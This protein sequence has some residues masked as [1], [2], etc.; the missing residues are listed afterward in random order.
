ML[1]VLHAGVCDGQFLLWGETPAEAEVLASRPLGRN[2]RLRAGAGRG[3]TPP[4]LPYD[5]GAKTLAA[6]LTAAG[7]ERMADM[8]PTEE[9]V[10]WLPTVEHT[11]VASSP[12]IDP[13]PL[14]GHG[15]APLRRADGRGAV[16]QRGAD[17]AGARG[18]HR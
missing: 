13:G 8:R 12:L 1:V 6:V 16:Q 2:R 7:F 14:G 5:A 10:A 4:R 11:P 9:V 15:A 18:D 3:R 17:D